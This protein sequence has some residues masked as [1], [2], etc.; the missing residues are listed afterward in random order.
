MKHGKTSCTRCNGQLERR[1]GRY[2]RMKLRTFL[3][4]TRCLHVEPEL[5]QEQAA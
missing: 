3:E 4:C 5:E 1:R 2:G